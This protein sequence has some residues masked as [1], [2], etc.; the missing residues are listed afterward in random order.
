MPNRRRKSDSG[1][2]NDNEEVDYIEETGDATDHN[3]NLSEPLDYNPAN[4]DPPATQV[5]DT[6]DP[7]QTL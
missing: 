6:F 4:A 1:N 3:S 7:V 5:N 2:E